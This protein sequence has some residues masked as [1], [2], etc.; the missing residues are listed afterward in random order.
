MADFVTYPSLYE[1]FGNALLETFY[2]SKPVLVN[3]YQVYKDDIEPHGFK[4][5]SIDGEITE[6]AVN[7]T[8]KLLS[9]D[10]L[11]EEWTSQ[12]YSICEEYF[13]HKVLRST[14][15]NLVGRFF[16]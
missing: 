11:V 16:E 10:S 3:R 13:S 5:I 6:D 9:D 4:V 1:G 8:I 15:E 2:F 14:L 12:N 7:D